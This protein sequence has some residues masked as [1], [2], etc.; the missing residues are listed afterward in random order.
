M[1]KPT[2]AEIDAAEIVIRANLAQMHQARYE[3]RVA[4]AARDLE[5]AKAAQLRAHIE[6]LQRQLAAAG[7]K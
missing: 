6:H 5:R 2:P 4:A 7:G 3:A 1:S